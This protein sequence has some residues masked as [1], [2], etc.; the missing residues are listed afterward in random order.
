MPNNC[1]NCDKQFTNAE[2]TE[3]GKINGCE[4]VNDV[5]TYECPYCNKEA[6]HVELS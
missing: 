4:V 2:L 1:S 3:I 5:A 6:I